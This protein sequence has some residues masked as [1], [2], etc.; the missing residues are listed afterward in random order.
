MKIIYKNIEI[1]VKENDRVIDV[2]RE[3]VE[4]NNNIIA[5]KINNEVKNLNYILKESRRRI[6]FYMLSICFFPL[7]PC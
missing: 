2:F 7:F 5:C 1:D 6:N 4:E 3:K